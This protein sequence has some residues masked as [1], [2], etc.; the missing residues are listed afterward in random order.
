M[1][2]IV[3]GMENMKSKKTLLD[4]IKDDHILN[5][6]K[7]IALLAISNIQTVSKI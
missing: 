6:N 5:V 2:D 7:S 4:I 3:V 1:N